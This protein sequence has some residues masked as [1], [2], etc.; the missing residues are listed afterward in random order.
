M[1]TPFK[2]RQLQTATTP[3]LSYGLALAT[4]PLDDFTLEWE[5]P[6][7]LTS[8]F[9]MYDYE[10]QFDRSLLGKTP[11]LSKTDSLHNIQVQAGLSPVL[12]H[13]SK[14]PLSVNPRTCTPIGP[15]KPTSLTNHFSS[16]IFQEKENLLVAGISVAPKIKRSFE[17]CIS[18]STSV[19][20]LHPPSKKQQS[21][22]PLGPSP[23]LLKKKKPLASQKHSCYEASCSTCN[24]MDVFISSEFLGVSAKG[25]SLKARRK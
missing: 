20:F 13:I 14:Q 19:Q 11:I 18:P 10:Q 2:Q 22:K 21:L 9:F 1:A 17:N 12:P 8:D 23:P 5:G 3:E 24:R 15:S 6:L 7:E 16:K 25:R 4:S